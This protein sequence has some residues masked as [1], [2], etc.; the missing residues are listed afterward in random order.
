[1]SRPALG[2]DAERRPGRAPG[3]RDA[4]GLPREAGGEHGPQ[5]VARALGTHAGLD[6][7]RLR[8]LRTRPELSLA[9]RGPGREPGSPDA[10]TDGRT[11][12]LDPGGRPGGRSQTS[13]PPASVQS[14]ASRRGRRVPGTV[15]RVAAPEFSSPPS[16]FSPEPPGAT[17]PLSGDSLAS[18]AMTE[19]QGGRWSG[20]PGAPPPG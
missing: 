20:W 16:S 2:K 14:V 15:S 3:P 9:G 11:R 10:G 13:G 6:G 17:F 7:S 18:S 4:P 8:G 5:S 1:M 19:P 12:G